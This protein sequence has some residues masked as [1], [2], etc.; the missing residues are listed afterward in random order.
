MVDVRALLTYKTIS[1]LLRFIFIKVDTGKNLAHRT[2]LIQKNDHTF[3]VDKQYAHP[4]KLDQW[5]R[6]IN[7]WSEIA[8]KVF[9]GSWCAYYECLWVDVPV[10]KHW[11]PD[12]NVVKYGYCRTQSSRNP[13]RELWY[14]AF[15]SGPTFIVD[16]TCAQPNFIDRMGND[17]LKWKIICW[18]R[19]EHEVVWDELVT[20]KESGG[21]VR[22]HSTLGLNSPYLPFSLQDVKDRVQTYEQEV[23]KL[24]GMSGRRRQEKSI[25]R[26]SL[27][28]VKEYNGC[29][30]TLDSLRPLW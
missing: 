11:L 4:A 16:H 15:R 20:G 28:L 12:G 8:Y 6:D 24:A 18:C 3:L 22:S 29:R 26:K 14:V 25:Y 30:Q 17:M 10:F 27:I 1:G 7:K 9:V 23:Q 21:V 5:K 13:D 19:L 2:I